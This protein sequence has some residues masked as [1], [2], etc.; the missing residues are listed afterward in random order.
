MP[1]CWQLLPSLPRTT[2]H[3][4]SLTSSLGPHPAFKHFSRGMA[5]RARTCPGATCS[6]ANSPPSAGSPAASWPWYRRIPGHRPPGGPPS[7]L[8]RPPSCSLRQPT[9]FST[10][11]QPS[12]P[13]TTSLT[14]RTSHLMCTAC[15]PLPRQRHATICPQPPPYRARSPQRRHLTTPPRHTRPTSPSLVLSATS[16]GPAQTG[17]R[18]WMNT[19]GTRART[20]MWA[21]L[22]GHHHAW[23]P[24]LTPRTGYALTRQPPTGPSSTWPSLSRTCPGTRYYPVPPHTLSYAPSRPLCPAP[25][26]KTPAPHGPKHTKRACSRGHSTLPKTCHPSCPHTPSLMLNTPAPRHHRALQCAQCSTTSCPTPCRQ[27]GGPAPT[28]CGR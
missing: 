4:R 16:T 19:H 22:P 3:A 27:P 15:A 23:Q 28:A 6:R 5:E 18:S 24:R 8:P 20:P 25:P 12:T 26:N 13:T 21:G 11:Y 1:G 17:A 7:P 9:P 14:N 10:L 2:S